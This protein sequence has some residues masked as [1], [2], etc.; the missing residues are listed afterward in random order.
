MQIQKTLVQVLLQ[1]QGSF[2]GVQSFPPLILGRL[3]DVLEEGA[4][5]ALVLHLQETLGALTLLLSQLAE[6]V[7]HT[8]QSHI[9]TVEIEALREGRREKR[10]AGRKAGPE[11]G[12]RPPTTLRDKGGQRVRTWGELRLGG[13][14]GTLTRER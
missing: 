9:V 2:H 1:N 6:E 11:R 13:V 8:F 12:L 10:L 4:A 14:L 3:L 5:P 7:A